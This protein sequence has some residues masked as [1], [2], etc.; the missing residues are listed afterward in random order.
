MTG[1]QFT[2]APLHI[3]SRA[4]LDGTSNAILESRICGSLPLVPTVPY[5]QRRT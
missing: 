2:V 5:S 1:V 4:E 3:S